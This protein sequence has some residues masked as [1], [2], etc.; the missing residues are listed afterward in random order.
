MRGGTQ[1]IEKLLNRKRTKRKRDD[2]EK[3]LYGEGVYIEKKYM[4]KENYTRRERHGG[5]IT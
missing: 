1:Y 4:R 3:G 5:V 2:I